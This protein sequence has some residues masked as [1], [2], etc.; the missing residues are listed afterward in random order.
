VFLMREVE[1]YPLFHSIIG[2]FVR[3]SSSSM[4]F[5]LK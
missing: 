3:Q 5:P 1:I 2:R 4:V